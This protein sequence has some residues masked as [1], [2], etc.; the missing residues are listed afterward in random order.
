MLI[1]LAA[2]TCGQNCERCQP[3]PRLRWPFYERSPCYRTRI[4]LLVAGNRSAQATVRSPSLSLLSRGLRELEVRSWLRTEHEL[5]KPRSVV[6]KVIRVDNNKLMSNSFSSHKYFG[7]S[8]IIVYERTAYRLLSSFDAVT[9]Q[10]NYITPSC[11]KPMSHMC[12]VLP[13]A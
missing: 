12:T 10:G 3:S 4:D 7:L 8:Q 11:G 6:S 5:N 1:E 2:R 9:P 13:Q